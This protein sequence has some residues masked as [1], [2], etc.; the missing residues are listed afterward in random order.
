MSRKAGPV[1][2]CCKSFSRHHRRTAE[3]FIVFAC[4]REASP[5]EVQS[6]R[7]DRRKPPCGPTF[8]SVPVDDWDRP[9]P[10]TMHS[11]LVQCGPRVVQACEVCVQS[12]PHQR[13]PCT[14]MALGRD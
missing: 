3:A 8:V 9:E 5:R 2:V 1:S 4:S 11:G 6:P 14:K 12:W 10:L 7:A 13:Q